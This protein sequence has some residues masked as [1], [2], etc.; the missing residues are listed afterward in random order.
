MIVID[1]KAI[2]R[3]AGFT[4]TAVANEMAAKRGAPYTVQNLSNRIR[5]D[6][7]KL[8]EFLDILEI[9]GLQLEIKTKPKE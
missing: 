9:L 6:Q 2:V 1:I 4:L 7:L 3:E 8:S 5:K